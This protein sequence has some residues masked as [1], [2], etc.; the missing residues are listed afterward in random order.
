MDEIYIH[1]NAHQLQLLVN[2]R[3]YMA[4]EP[5]R[6]HDAVKSILATLP[7]GVTLLAA[8][9]TRSLEEVKAVITAGVTHIGY[10]YVQEALPIIQAVGSQASWHMIGHLQRNKARVVVENFDLVETL[11]SLKLA[12]AIERYCEETQKTLPVLLEINSGRESNKTGVLPED[13]DELVENF[14]ALKFV[15]V[16]GLMTMGPL[17][18]DP[19]ASRPY[20]KTTREI[21]ERLSNVTTPNVEM[22]TLSM[23]MSNSYR[24]AIEEG[25]NLVRLGTAIFGARPVK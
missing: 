16:E 18:G 13:V 10:N 1:T 8:A 4:I 3:Q 19:E 2:E 17:F 7:P 11:D 21:Y 9:K 6:I 5:D 24:V 25:A 20:F 12:H 23:G 15:R 22:R 14:S